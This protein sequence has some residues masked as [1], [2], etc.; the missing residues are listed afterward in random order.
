MDPTSAIGES[1]LQA[2]LRQLL[3]SLE[4]N[5]S[6]NPDLIARITALA[7]EGK[8]NS[9]EEITRILRPSNEGRS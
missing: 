6:F 5:S 8:L 3:H 1:P 9:R 7:H 2:I 4:A